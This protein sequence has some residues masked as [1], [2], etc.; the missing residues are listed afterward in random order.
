[1]SS[2]RS[3]W[4]DLWLRALVV[5]ALALLPACNARAQPPDAL[6]SEVRAVIVRDALPELRRPGFS[7]HAKSLDRFYA[8]RSHALAWF[9]RSNSRPVVATALAQ[10]RRAPEQGLATEDYDVDWLAQEV[11]AIETG[12][13]T[14]ARVARAD[15]ALTLTLFRYLSELHLGRVRPT[16]AEFRYAVAYREH[17]LD[18][19]L[20]RALLQNQLAQVI[21]AAEPAFPMY[22]RLKSLLARY[23]Q[24]AAKPIADLPPL[25]PRAKR[26][27]PGERYHGTPQLR[28]RL[29]LLGD[30]S[31]DS[32]D[33][34]A[35]L[36]SDEV[37]DALKRFQE[38][39]GLS[40]DGVLGRQTLAQLNVPPAA[41]VR[42]IALALER[43]RWIPDLPPGPV[44][45][46]NIPSYRLL[47]FTDLPESDRVVLRMRV[48]V[49]RAVR[50][51]TPV[52][53]GEM[54]YVEFSP[55]WNVP[56]SIQKN[57][58]VPRLMRDPGYLAREEM[59]LVSKR[60]ASV[61]TA[62][63]AQTLAALRA[64][65]WRIRQR[66]GPRNALDGVKFVLPNTMNIYLH[67][68]PSPRLFEPARRDFSHGCIRVE[69]PVALARFVLRDQAQ[70][71]QERIREAMSSGTTR[72][73]RLGRDIPVVIFYTTVIVDAEGRAS[74][75]PDVYGYDRKLEQALRLRSAGAI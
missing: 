59:E 35:E 30:L 55:Y 42:Q 22:A 48:I 25:P 19:T 41:R 61:T 16:D 44:L 34:D 23:R 68:T 31:T 49:G 18:A 50:T 29:R 17:A 32:D 11:R 70:W 51:P 4:H 20:S 15:V 67:G 74:F 37:V 54:R 14:P 39:H 43:L 28:Q 8:A 26:I 60:D 7:V 72:T 53:L 5:L 66:P 12:A 10:L 45:I 38:R 75:L 58:I 21:A 13:V 40:P 65:T 1:M 47:A 73:V 56:P 9:E 2:F 27:K 69:D 33:S 63:D 46:I 6:Q 52:F 62:L 64:G 3:L 71:T 36:F 57:E 24:I